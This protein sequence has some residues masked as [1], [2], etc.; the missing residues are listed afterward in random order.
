M[1]E[2][3]KHKCDKCHQCVESRIFPFTINGKFVWLCSKCWEIVMNRWKIVM[4]RDKEVK[5]E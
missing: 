1:S 3:Y 2:E 5:H 4:N